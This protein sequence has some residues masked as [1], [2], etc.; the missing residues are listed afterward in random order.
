MSIKI[1]LSAVRNL[2]VQGGLHAEF[3]K[4][5]S[6]RLELVLKGIKH[7]KARTAP[8][9]TRLPITVDIIWEK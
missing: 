1:Y 3:A 2:H 8:P 6:P 4:Q 5:L 7:E 9:P